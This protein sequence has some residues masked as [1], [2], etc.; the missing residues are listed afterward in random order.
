MQ[1]HGSVMSGSPQIKGKTTDEAFWEQSFLWENKASVG[2]DFDIFNF[3]AL[4][5]R[6][7]FNTLKQHCG[8][9]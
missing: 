1:M 8:I 6:S 2:A 7:P 5:H 9:I 4:L 3:Q